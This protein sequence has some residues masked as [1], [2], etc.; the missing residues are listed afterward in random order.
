MAKFL[1]IALVFISLKSFSQEVKITSFRSSDTFNDSSYIISE[2][3]LK[4]DY[5]K[6][7]LIVSYID[8][9]DTL[10]PVYEIML[11][12]FDDKWIN[13][14]SQTVYNYTN[15]F[16]GKYQFKVRNMRFPDKIAS[17]NFEIE[18]AF[19][20]RPW[21]AVSIVGYLMLIAGIIFYFF[22]TA[23]LKQQNR[24]QTVRNEIS[25]DLH[26][27]VG[28]TLAN[29]SFLTE[30][31]QM[32]LKESKSSDVEMILGKIL[33]DSKL[34]VQTMRGLIW[35]IKPENDDAVDFFL[36][37]KNLANDFLSPSEVKLKFVQKTKKDLKLS[38]EIQR[39]LFLVM[40]ESIH[41]ILKHA[42]ATEVEIIIK[43][44]GS[45]LLVQMK[46]NGKGFDIGEA[47]S[48]N[49]LI[50]IQKRILSLNGTVEFINENGLKLR[51]AIPMV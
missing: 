39:N 7:H 4:L 13:V 20:Q 37:V 2:K 30:I 43:S 3:P 40:K 50:N 22:Q 48:G 18:E 11:T 21:F 45:W 46:D 36:K 15:L 31:A 1:L 47:S 26:D 5:R 17:L 44:E 29:I 49:G 10:S 42:H 34:M 33:E 38:L 32:R 41:N 35:T 12:G 23:R 51:I 25:S 28:S 14:G 6:S 24:F 9:S 27:D 8:L 19:W 16:G